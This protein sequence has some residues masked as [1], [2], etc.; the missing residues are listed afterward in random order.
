RNRRCGGPCA[1]LSPSPLASRMADARPRAARKRQILSFLRNHGD[2]AFRHK[3]SAKPP[4]VQGNQRYKLFR[5]ALAG[6]DAA[7]LVDK[8][9]GGR[10]QHK[11]ARRR[12]VA[13]GTPTVNPGGFGFV[14]VDGM[15]ED[16]FIPPPRLKTGLDG[17]RVKIE[18]AA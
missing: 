8:A 13:E 3:E 2:G 6:R 9:K 5:S 18:L 15:E 14:A 16:V 1:H 10:Y 12:N 11:K 7:G 4:T 17:D